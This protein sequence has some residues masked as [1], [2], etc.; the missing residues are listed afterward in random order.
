MWVAAA[1]AVAT[2]V[3]GTGVANGTAI[4]C[5]EG[6]AGTGVLVCAG[7]GVLVCAAIGVFPCVGAGVAVIVTTATG[8][9][10]GTCVGV[11]VASPGL[12]A[13]I[14]AVSVGVDVEGLT[15]RSGGCVAVG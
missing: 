9:A 6:T 7:T 15:A 13:G 3:A 5:G 2:A 14:A 12:A 1:V 10:V 8:V 11:E 4:I